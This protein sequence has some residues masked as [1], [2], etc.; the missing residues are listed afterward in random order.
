MSVAKVMRRTAK[1]HET[2]VLKSVIREEKLDRAS[3]A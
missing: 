2:N 3:R 1:I